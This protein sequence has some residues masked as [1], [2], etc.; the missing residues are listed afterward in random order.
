[1]R[2]LDQNPH[3]PVSVHTAVSAPANCTPRT[4]LAG[5]WP[6][7]T[8][9]FWPPFAR[10]AK[11]A[12]GCMALFQVSILVAQLL[13]F[14]GYFPFNQHPTIWILFTGSL[15]ANLMAVAGGF[16][17]TVIAIWLTIMAGIFLPEWCK[18]VCN[19]GQ[20]RLAQK[21]VDQK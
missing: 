5:L 3:G 6:W 19:K 8:D 15:S 4:F 12:L 18:T 13:D 11:F 9:C 20:A 10:P 2:S 21:G 1:M 7:V 17:P 14:L 16:F